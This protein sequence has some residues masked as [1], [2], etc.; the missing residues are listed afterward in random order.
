M[1]KN[2]VKHIN[3][4]NNVSVEAFDMAKLDEVVKQLKM[5]YRQLDGYADER[6]KAEE[7]NGQVQALMQKAMDDCDLEQLTKLT[8]ERKRLLQKLAETDAP[9]IQRFDECVNDLVA[10]ATSTNGLDKT[11]ETITPMKKAA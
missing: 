2:T 6:A 7:R 3:D 8:A 9:K 5:A 1:G 10:I 4:A 11:V